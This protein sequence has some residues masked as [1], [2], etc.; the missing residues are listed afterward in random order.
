MTT[1]ADQVEKKVGGPKGISY[2]QLLETC[3]R[4]VSQAFPKAS[5]EARV[6]MTIAV[7]NAQMTVYHATAIAQ[8]LGMPE[9]EE[10]LAMLLKE[11][12][13]GAA[14]RRELELAK[15]AGP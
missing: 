6:Q 13:A 15:G 11:Q 10:L 5:E 8:A 7:F 1:P 4:D 14:L 2:A 3:R 9:K 12:R